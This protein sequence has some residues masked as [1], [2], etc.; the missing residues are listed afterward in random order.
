[1]GEDEFRE[2]S[3]KAS[4]YKNDV[5]DRI[6]EIRESFEI[7]SKGYVS[8]DYRQKGKYNRMFIE[9][10][11]IK[12]AARAQIDNLEINIEKIK[13]KIKSTIGKDS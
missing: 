2:F 9:F 12:A 6:A 13:N 3:K 11:M 1:M 7:L 4:K 5:T 8:K 10:P